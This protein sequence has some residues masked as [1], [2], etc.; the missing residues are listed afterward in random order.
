MLAAGFFLVLASGSAA[1]TLT[2]T[3]FSDDGSP[4][5]LRHLIENEAK[6]GDTIVFAGPGPIELTGSLGIPRRLA[7]LKIQGPVVL[8]VDPPPAG[9]RFRRTLN[10]N[11]PKVTLAGLT[12][13]DLDVRVRKAADVTVRDSTFTEG[14]EIEVEDSP[15]ASIRSN[16]FSG[17]SSVW[18]VRIAGRASGGAEIVGNAI[19]GGGIEVRGFPRG[20]TVAGNI[21][22]ERIGPSGIRIHSARGTT[23]RGNA[24]AGFGK[25]ID[26]ETAPGANI[27]G[28]TVAGNG[29]GINVELG[30]GQRLKGNTVERNGGDGIRIKGEA[31]VIGG[32]IRDN[33]GAGIFVSPG[34]SVW[35]SRVKMENNAGPGLDVAPRGVTPNDKRKTANGNLDSPITRYDGAARKVRGRT[36]GRCRV[37]VFRTEAGARHGNPGHGE[38]A[39]FLGAVVAAPSGAFT[40]PRKGRIGCGAA[41]NLTM[42][43]TRT[44]KKGRVTSEFSGDV[45]CGAGRG[46]TKLGSPVRVSPPLCPAPPAGAEPASCSRTDSFLVFVPRNARNARCSLVD[47][48][49]GVATTPEWPLFEG[50]GQEQSPCRFAGTRAGGRV[51]R[52]DVKLTNP[53]DLPDRQFGSRRVRLYAGWD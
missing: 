44:T 36:C 46:G 28:N 9:S 5:T 41:R 35:S 18:R 40:W 10:V 3:N 25:G 24:I 19:A 39:R 17:G 42:T 1:A 21:I 26:L 30:S 38:G 29:I 11:A 49:T 31:N 37:E 43:T 50:F 33:G 13:E 45:G 6:P 52:L 27:T 51:V 4:G 23:I 34:G 32:T 2:V 15:D 22:T 20:V 48:A 16:S 8:K 14:A 53:G 12:F 7:G 47:A